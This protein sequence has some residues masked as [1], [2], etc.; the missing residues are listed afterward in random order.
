VC[1]APL[2]LVEAHQGLFIVVAGGDL[3][4][5]HFQ[6]KAQDKN[7]GKDKGHDVPVFPQKAGPGYVVV[8]PLRD[9]SGSPDRRLVAV[10]LLLVSRLPQA[11]PQQ[12]L[13][14]QVISGPFMGV[15][16]HLIGF[17]YLL[18]SFFK[19]GT[20]LMLVGMVEPGQLFIGHFYLPGIGGSSH[21]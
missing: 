9:G 6:K 3:V 10:A 18:E 20:T 16:Q 12:I 11:F 15:R 8:M 14:L 2:L 7:A 17:I 19:K 4:H 1:P 13:Q 5:H 21:L